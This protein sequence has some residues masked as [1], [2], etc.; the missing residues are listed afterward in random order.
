MRFRHL[1]RQSEQPTLLTR[2]MTKWRHELRW[3][4]WAIARSDHEMRLD[5]W[6]RQQFPAAPQSLLQAQLRKRKIRILASTEDPSE[7]ERAQAQDDA[8]PPA[9]SA[10]RTRA[11]SVL[12][13]GLTVAIDAHV[14]RHKLQPASPASTTHQTQTATRLD[15]NLPLLQELL[16]RIAYTDDNYIVLDKPPGLAVQVRATSRSGFC[17]YVWYHGLTT[18]LTVS[19]SRSRSCCRALTRSS[20]AALGRHWTRDVARRLPRSDRSG[21]GSSSNRCNV[22]ARASTRQRDVWTPC[23]RSESTRSR[24]VHSAPAGRTRA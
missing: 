4:R 12:R 8:A 19:F 22:S 21:S 13:E 20:F 10:Q 2:I 11:N 18:S 15:R 17:V 3:M 5:R 6:L 23:A 7:H 16:A 1:S 24:Q 14:F 9:A